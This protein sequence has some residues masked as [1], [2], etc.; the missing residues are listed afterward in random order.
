MAK[1]LP[2]FQD[3]VAC[4]PVRS[5]TLILA[6]TESVCCSVFII[7]TG[8]AGPGAIWVCA[9]GAAVGK[10]SAGTVLPRIRQALMAAA[11]SCVFL[12]KIKVPPLNKYSNAID[13]NATYY[14]PFEEKM[15]V[16]AESGYDAN[17]EFGDHNGGSKP[18]PYA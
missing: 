4:L 5:V 17:T 10:A 2:L 12:I 1:G 6:W 11:A 7:F 8:R 9:V 14:I 18:P 3:R 13:S 15:Q 16:R